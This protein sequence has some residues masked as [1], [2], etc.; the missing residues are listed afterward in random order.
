[1]NFPQSTLEKVQL[2]TND[3]IGLRTV[4]AKCINGSVD[5]LRKTCRVFSLPESHEGF[6][7]HEC[8]QCE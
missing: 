1:M 3:P 4:N 2:T 7:N 8:P 6:L 5:W